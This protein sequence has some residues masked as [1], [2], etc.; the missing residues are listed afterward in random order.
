MSE[1]LRDCFP[2]AGKL[3]EVSL[4][5]IENEDLVV[6]G[7]GSTV[8]ALSLHI[9]SGCRFVGRDVVSAVSITV[10]DT[11]E[12]RES[13]RLSIRGFRALRSGSEPRVKDASVEISRDFFDGA[14][15]TGR[16][17]GFAEP[18]IS[19]LSTRNSSELARAEA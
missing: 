4:S 10:K 6:T 9:L 3:I 8:N 13:G 2:L 19:G 17:S 15:F 11:S 14:D 18:I 16:T 1:I 7:S 5:A 12:Q